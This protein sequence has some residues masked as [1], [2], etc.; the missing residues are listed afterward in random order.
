MDSRPVDESDILEAARRLHGL[1][2]LD[3]IEYA[4]VERSGDIS[5]IPRTSTDSE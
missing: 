1:R 5:I 2:R 3:Q 4:V